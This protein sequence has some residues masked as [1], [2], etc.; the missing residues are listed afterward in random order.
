MN[1]IKLKI[2]I[3]IING[4]YIGKF[5]NEMRNGK[6]ILF[7]ILIMAIDQKGILEMINKKEKKYNI[8]I[9]ANGKMIDMKEIIEMIKT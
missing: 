7:L 5:G 1:S 2:I 9:I 3:L 6:W 8:G 4:K